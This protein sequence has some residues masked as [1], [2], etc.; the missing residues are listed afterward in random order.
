MFDSHKGH[1]VCRIEEGAKD[2]R[3]RINVAAKD[4]ILQFEKTESV[5]LDVRHA[6]LT[7][8]ENSE[9]IIAM[10]EKQF[11]DLLICVKTR[12]AKFL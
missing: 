5:L 12:K 3:T 4:G 11:D 6:K 10:A 1:E 8:D 2:I 9:A 7:L